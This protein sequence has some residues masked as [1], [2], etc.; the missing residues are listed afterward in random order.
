M[1]RQVRNHHDIFSSM[2]YQQKFMRKSFKKDVSAVRELKNIYELFEENAC[3]ASTVF[4]MKNLIFL[5][6]TTAHVIGEFVVKVIGKVH[7]FKT[8]RR[9]IRLEV[10]FMYFYI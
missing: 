1:D 3:H 7:I 8:R 2:F 6:W 4:F 9:K 10:Q 5:L